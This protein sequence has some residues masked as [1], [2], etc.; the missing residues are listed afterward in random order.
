MQRNTAI[1]CLSFFKLLLQTPHARNTIYFRGFSF[2]SS[3]YINQPYLLSRNYC[4]IFFIK[5]VIRSIS[6]S[7]LYFLVSKIWIW[8]ILL[9]FFLKIKFFYCS[10]LLISKNLALIYWKYKW[11]ERDSS[12]KNESK[13]WND[14]FPCRRF[15]FWENR[16]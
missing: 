1:G 5:I 8:I 9:F 6:F 11:K 7:F 12:W 4:V 10:I 3:I 2:T 16:L 13:M 15:C 14:I